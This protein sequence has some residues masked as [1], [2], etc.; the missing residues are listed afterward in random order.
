MSGYFTKKYIYQVSDDYCAAYP[1][2]HDNN[3]RTG[4]QWGKSELFVENGAIYIATKKR[5]EKYKTFRSNSSIIY[6]M[7]K[8]DSIEIDTLE[9]LQ[10]VKDKRSE[11]GV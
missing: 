11:Y 2:N 6:Q 8:R 4:R 7:E 10:L 3:Y 5:I 9:Q 1:I